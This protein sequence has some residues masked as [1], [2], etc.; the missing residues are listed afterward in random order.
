M[1]DSPI[2]PILG[3]DGHA[4]VFS[5]ELT[6]T[7]SRRYTPDYDATLDAYLMQLRVHGLSHGVLVQP[8]F[9]GTDNRYLLA[10]LQRA[11]DQLRGVAVVDP[12]TQFKELEEMAGQGI[13]GIRLNLMGKALPEFAEPQ[14]QRL[15]GHVAQLGWHVELHRG[16]EDLPGLIR[17]L[18]PY[19]CRIVVDHFGRPDAPSGVDHPAFQALLETGSTGQVWVKIS[20]IYRLGG[21]PS[22]N[23]AFA[24]AALPLLVRHFGLNHLVWGSDW[25]HTQHEQGV[26]FETVVE[27]LRE[28][29]C[30]D[31]VRRAL[32]IDAPQGLFEFF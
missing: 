2:P 16:V 17:S 1:P 15:F 22:Q 32:M 6:L 7:S 19:G 13:V 25:P 30:G 27:Q 18:L 11:P 31:D 3:I 9:L 21:N 20:A 5:R 4:H 28:L 8:S 14:W 29:D 23:M 24:R 10:A 12:D 26:C